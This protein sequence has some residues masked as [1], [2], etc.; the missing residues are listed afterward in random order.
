MIIP[1]AYP[2]IPMCRESSNIRVMS[3]GRDGNGSE[4]E[5]VVGENDASRGS[6]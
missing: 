2:R 6:F 3:I 4:L 5:F 1:A